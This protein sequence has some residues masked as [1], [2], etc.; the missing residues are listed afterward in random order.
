M[1]ILPDPQQ[2]QQSWLKPEKSSPHKNTSKEKSLKFIGTHRDN[3]LIPTTPD[4]SSLPLSRGR[5]NALTNS[6]TAKI[7]SAVNAIKPSITA[8]KTVPSDLK[9]SAAE[10]A[11]ITNPAERQEKVAAKLKELQGKDKTVFCLEVFKHLSDDDSL[12][13]V[14]SFVDD[15][16]STAQLN[17]DPG[18]FLRG[19]SS[20]ATTIPAFIQYMLE[21]ANPEFG[22]LLA[23]IK[24]PNQTTDVSMILT[25]L[26]NIT[27]N[28]PIQLTQMHQ[29]IQE[30]VTAKLKSV[31]GKDPIECEQ[32]GKRMALN[33]ILLRLIGPALAS[34]GRKIP[35]SKTLMALVK[36]I[37]LAK[38]AQTTQVVPPTEQEQLLFAVIGVHLFPDTK[39]P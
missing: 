38:T 33:P 35:V 24:D 9:T 14:T 23:K 13:L 22:E 7:S 39:R 27:A 18:A 4:G 31:P 29:H 11:K 3:K 30:Q 25:Q 12:A 28:S 20:A 34:E 10:I 36:L 19:A 21:K 26:V 32:I 37:Q 5:A 1:E 2:D 17:D 15:Y 16:I 6:D 8:E